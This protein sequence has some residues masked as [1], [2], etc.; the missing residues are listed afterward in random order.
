MKE[1]GVKKLKWREP[2]LVK[3]EPNKEH[4]R[5]KQCAKGY[6]PPGDCEAGTGAA[7]SCGTGGNGS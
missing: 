3:F 5:G 4:A 1:Q 7:N 2:S 6:W